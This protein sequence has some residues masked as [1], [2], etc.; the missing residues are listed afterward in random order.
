MSTSCV[1]AVKLFNDSYIATVCNFDGYYDGVGAELR[2]H[3]TDIGAPQKLVEG[4]EIRCIN[5][6]EVEYYA[7]SNFKPVTMNEKE[8]A[9]MRSEWGCSYTHLYVAGEWVTL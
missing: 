1:I 4:G 3:F 8:L 9:G 6:G 7:K 2:E 5:K